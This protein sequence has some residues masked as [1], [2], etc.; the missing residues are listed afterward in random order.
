MR[1]YKFSRFLL[2][3]WL[4]LFY[5]FEAIGVE[6]LQ[7]NK[8]YILCPNHQ[9]NWD[10]PLV[11]IPLSMIVH[12][13]A[14]EEMFKVPIL[15]QMITAYGAYPVN[16]ERMDKNTYRTTTRLL[17][18]NKIIFIFPEGTRSS[19]V[20]REGAATFAIRTNTPIVPVAI[21]GTYRLFSKMTVI[22]G[23]PLTFTHL[24]DLPKDEKVKAA[25][26]EIMKAIH[27]LMEERPS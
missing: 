13:M 24:D 14:K 4:K 20:A 5:R 3:V 23:T 10:P 25:T 21:V 8:A 16:R 15:K 1:F 27:K 9:S 7:P 26:A 19:G 22:Y 17:V 12:F 6:N 11:G 2:R 18:E